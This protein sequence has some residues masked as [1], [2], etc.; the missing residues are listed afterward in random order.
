M[1]PILKITA[2]LGTIMHIQVMTCVLQAQSPSEAIILPTAN[3]HLLRNENEKFYMYVYRNFEGQ[4]SRPWTAGKYGF[5]R[6]LRR[7]ED[8]VLCTKFHEGIDIKPLK[9]DRNRNPL[10]EVRAI[11]AGTVAYVNSTAGNSNYGKYIVIEHPWQCGPLYSLYAHLATTDVKEGQKLKIG[12]NIGRMGYTGA[13]LNRDRAHL[14]LELGIMSSKRFTTWQQKHFHSPNHHGNCNGMNIIGLDIASFY[15]ARQKNPEL[16]IPQFVK[17]I[18]VHYKVTIPR[19]QLKNGSPELL[20]RYPWLASAEAETFTPSWEISFS[21]S[22]FPT[23]ITPSN[24]V[25]S[26][27]SISSICK[28]QSKHEYHTKGF[29]SGSGDRG[30]LSKTGKRFIELV[31]G[32]F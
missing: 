2:I 5:V 27:A 1:H 25:V 13:G 10:D 30:S 31:C 12:Q 26:A 11:A 24:R 23:S 17:S 14:H 8:G 28:C 15:L 3:D 29:V 7:T 32:Q 22:G 16:T 18:P 9:R 21:T 19:N 4:E 6:S 20:K